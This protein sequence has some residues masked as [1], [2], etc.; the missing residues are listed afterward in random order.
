VKGVPSN[1][2]ARR[3]LE[4]RQAAVRITPTNAGHAQAWRPV[5]ACVMFFFFCGALGPEQEN[6]KV[7]LREPE[8]G[9]VA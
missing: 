9:P 6:C 7:F 8:V 5:G 4:D 3:R 2:I 1:Y